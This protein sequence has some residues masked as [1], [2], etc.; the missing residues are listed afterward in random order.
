MKKVIIIAVIVLVIFGLYI[1]KN[2]SEVKQV[3]DN[4]SQVSTLKPDPSNATFEFEGDTIT[5][6]KGKALVAIE[7]SSIEEEVSLSTDMAYGDLNG[8]KK[9]DTAV[10]LARAGGG[11]GVFIYVAGFVSGNSY[12]GTNAVFIGDRIKP[13]SISIDNG[14]I[15][16]VYLDRRPSEPFA[17]EPTVKTTAEF[18]YKSGE[19]QEK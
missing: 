7:G 13:Q 3:P 18:V 12:Q 16:V 1:F 10:I 4:N 5:L 11:S 2:K 17:A 9:T 14:V 8:D 15:T 6:S 19:L